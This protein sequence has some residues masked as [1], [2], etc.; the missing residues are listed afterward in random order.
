MGIEHSRRPKYWRKRAEQ[1]K[2]MASNCG[3][4][5]APETLQKAAREYEKLAQLAELPR[6]NLAR[7]NIWSD[8]EVAKLKALAGTLPVQELANNFERSLQ[9]IRNKALLLRVSLRY[10]P[11]R[12]SPSRRP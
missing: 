4:G 2:T 7:E 8:I 10:P 9:A 1:C 5:R 6:T 11:G 3:G 12:S